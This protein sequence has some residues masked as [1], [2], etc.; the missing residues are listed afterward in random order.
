MPAFVAISGAVYFYIKR[1]KQR[2]NNQIKFINNKLKRLILPYIFFAIVVTIPTLYICGLIHGNIIKYIVYN[3][4]FAN[5]CRHLWYLIMLFGIM[6]IFNKIETYIYKNKNIALVI[7]LIVSVFFSFHYIGWFQISNILKYFFF[8]MVGYYFQYYRDRIINVLTNKYRL[9]L[10][11]FILITSILIFGIGKKICMPNIIINYICAILTS[12]SLY[13]IS[14]TISN[15]KWILDFKIF[16]YIDKN[17]LGIYLFSPMIIYLL[18]HFFNQ[19]TVMPYL[20][21]II[22]FLIS[23]TLSILLTELMRLFKLQIF[24]GEN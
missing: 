12:I 18:F 24:I 20:T 15:Y 4:V 14:L 3:Y 17:N 11:I 1:V 5:D 8:F 23:L 7:S 13:L 2:Y 9:P 6:I 19:I 10:S 16:K 21:T 22:F